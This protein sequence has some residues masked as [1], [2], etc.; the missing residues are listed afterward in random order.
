MIVY[1]TNFVKINF[2]IKKEPQ[3][4]GVFLAFIRFNLK[5]SPAGQ[6]T[7]KACLA[8]KKHYQPLCDGHVM[9]PFKRQFFIMYNQGS[10]K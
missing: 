6:Q 1:P 8:V 3:M 4:S 10:N 2:P 5:W 7:G 9:F